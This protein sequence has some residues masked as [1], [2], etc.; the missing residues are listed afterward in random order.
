[1]NEIYRGTNI[2]VSNIDDFEYL[3]ERTKWLNFE[4][5]NGKFCRFSGESVLKD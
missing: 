5:V 3:S 2:L 1:M 4:E